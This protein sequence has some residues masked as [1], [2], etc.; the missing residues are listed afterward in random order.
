MRNLSKGYSLF[1][2]P[3]ALMCLATSQAP[4]A[5]GPGLYRRAVEFR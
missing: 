5:R 4:L 2:V 3:I 1:V